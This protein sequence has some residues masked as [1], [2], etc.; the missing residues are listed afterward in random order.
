[1]CWTSD[2]IYWYYVAKRRKLNSYSCT[3]QCYVQHFM[4]NQRHYDPYGQTSHVTTLN[5]VIGIFDEFNE[6]KRVQLLTIIRPCA[7][8]P[9]GKILLCKWPS[10]DHQNCYTG[11]C[12]DF[13]PEH[14]GQDL[15]NG[16]IRLANCSESEY[17][18]GTMWE[19][20]TARTKGSLRCGLTYAAYLAYL[21]A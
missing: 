3:L 21:C 9:F 8:F 19:K 7:R 20:E 17:L 12:G 2:N 16:L 11:L 1:M 15:K 10:G 14:D 4:S 5:F 18:A 6:K 13:Q